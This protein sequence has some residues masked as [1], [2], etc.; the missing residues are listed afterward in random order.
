MRI[1]VSS[2]K[3]GDMVS[4]WWKPKCAMIEKI[5]KYHHPTVP[6]ID[7]ILRFYGGMAMSADSTDYMDKIN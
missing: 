4:V 5:E 1:K 7:T 6:E 2:L 3:I